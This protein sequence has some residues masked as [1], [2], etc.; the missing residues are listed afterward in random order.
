M[1]FLRKGKLLDAVKVDN[2]EKKGYKYC[3]SKGR[4]SFVGFCPD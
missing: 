2:F 4:P 3:Q 1:K